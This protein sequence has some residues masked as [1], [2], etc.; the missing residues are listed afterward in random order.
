MSSAAAGPTRWAGAACRP[1]R[2]DAE[3]DFRQT[4]LGAGFIDRQQVA[5]GQR[6]FQAAA[7]AMA[8]H[9]RQG[10]VLDGFQAVEQLPA[11]LDE[12]PA[13]FGVSSWENSPM[14]A[15]AMNPAPC[16]SG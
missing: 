10:R 7:Q 11:A 14:S 2:E 13:L 15:P 8:T 5:A 9:Q 4:H 3:H 16:R 12:R 1:S 6:Q